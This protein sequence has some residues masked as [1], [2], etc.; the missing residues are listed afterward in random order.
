M[1]NR[2]KSPPLGEHKG[3]SCGLTGPVGEGFL[4]AE[5]GS[6]GSRAE[7]RARG[8]PTALQVHGQGE[9]KKRLFGAYLC[10]GC[11][12]PSRHPDLALSISAR[13]VGFLT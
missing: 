2:E 4:H 5:S 1:R 11:H 13:V 9:E 3:A 12:G 10:M 8:H 7:T 6:Q